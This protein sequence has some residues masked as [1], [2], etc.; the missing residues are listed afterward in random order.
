ME[1]ELLL[2]RDDDIAEGSLQRI[3]AADIDFCVTRLNGAIRVVEDR[4]PHM[5]V[6]LSF[7]TL[8]DC[9][10]TCPQHRAQFDLQD[11]S[12]VAP[13]VMGGGNAAAAAASA[14]ALDPEAAARAERRREMMSSVRTKSLVV[15][16]V[17]E[18]DGNVY[19]LLA[20]ER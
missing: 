20:N 16:P 5:S 2:A 13:P 19:V 6:P 12:L 17:V 15:F 8:D 9:V 10:V 14:G 4:C 1:R 7:G 3:T 18:R 11:Y